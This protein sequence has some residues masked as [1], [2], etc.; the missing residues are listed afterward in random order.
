V[1]DDPRHL[2]TDEQRERFAEATT[3]GGICGGCGRVLA[4]GDAVYVEKIEIDLKPLTGAGAGWFRKTVYRD[5]PLG[6]ECVSPV[7]LAR[8]AEW[9][10]ERCVGCGRPVYYATERAGRHRASCSKYCSYRGAQRARRGE[11][12]R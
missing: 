12:S 2:T 11:D 7:F 9:E 3:R 5:A 6:V 4:D 8:T 1:S 10:P